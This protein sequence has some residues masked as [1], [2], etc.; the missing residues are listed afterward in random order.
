VRKQS[1]IIERIDDADHHPIYRAAHVAAPGLDPGATWMTS[2]LM[3][4]VLTRGTAASA[5][6]LGFKLPAAGKTGTTNEFKDAWFL[7]YT[8]AL[9]CGVW[10]GFDQPQKIMSGGYGAT[11]ALPVWTSVMSKA[12]Q[13]YPAHAFQTDLQMA[14]ATVCATSNRLATDGCLAAGSAYEITLPVSRVPITACPIHSGGLQTQPF[15]Q[16]MDDAGRKAEALPGKIISSFRRFF[17]RK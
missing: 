7:G 2:Q 15:A 5:R 9:T 4:Q 1:Y 11:L 12:A 6:S 14:R 17:G 3:E 10:V 13:Q 16:R 8:S